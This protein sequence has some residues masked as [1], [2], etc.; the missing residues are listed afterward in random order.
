MTAYVLPLLLT[1]AAAALTYV[2]CIRPM[3]RGGSCHMSAQPPPA[4]SA[5]TDDEIQR[6]RE[7]V[8]LL[9]HEAD[10]APRA[11]VPLDKEDPL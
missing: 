5:E 7:E 11:A 2:F 6:L 10:L 1:V 4:T 9:R 8:Q 3:R